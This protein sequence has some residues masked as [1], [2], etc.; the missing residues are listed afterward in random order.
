MRLIIEIKDEEISKLKYMV[1]E[2]EI[3]ISTIFEKKMV[4]DH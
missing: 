2:M 4:P 1:N 3:T